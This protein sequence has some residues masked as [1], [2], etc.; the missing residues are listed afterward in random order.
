MPC[1]FRTG[2]ETHRSTVDLASDGTIHHFP[3]L[4]EPDPTTGMSTEPPALSSSTDGGLTWSQQ[5]IEL[6][7]IDE[8]SPARW[9]YM[10]VDPATDRI[11][12]D[13]YNDWDGS[14]DQGDEP[15]MVILSYSDDGGETWTSTRFEGSNNAWQGLAVGPT[16]TSSTQGYPNAVYRCARWLALTVPTYDHYGLGCHQSLDGGDT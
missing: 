10:M 9:P 6:G 4:I 1:L 2:V 11:F 14:Y 13:E 12:V 5:A 15:D 3:K 16:A 8:R 7:P